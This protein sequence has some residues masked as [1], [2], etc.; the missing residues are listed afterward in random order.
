MTTKK[1][2]SMH[3]VY[4][5]SPGPATL[6][7]EVLEQ[8]REEMLDWR[9]SGMSIIEMSHR[10][11]QFMEIAGEAEQDCRELLAIPDSYNVL[12]LQGGATL[13]FA[14]VPLNIAGPDAVVNYVNT[15]SWSKKAIKEAER[16]CRVH[17]AADSASL[18]YNG[19]P[20]QREWNVDPGGAYLHYTPNE[21]IG[22]VEFHF[23]PDSHGV[24]LVADMSSTV[25][26][27]PI[28]VSRF[29]VIYAG[30][31]KNI[32]PSG[33]TLV[34]VRED[35]V[36]KARP[37]TPTVMNYQVMADTGSMSNTPN[38]FAWYMAGLVFKW[39][40][41]QGG[42]GVMGERNQVKAEK[43]YR[44]IDRSSFYHNPVEASSRSCMNVPFTLADP[45]LD[46]VFL[47]QAAT[48]GLVNLKGHRSVGGMRASLYNAMPEAGV[49]ALVTFM[50]EFEQV[51]R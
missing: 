5:F 7:V 23:I 14:S 40:K 22:G 34:I 8:V 41:T 29:G 26:S 45:D 2:K 44:A 18:E 37:D 28:D 35:L 27:R 42:L 30:A 21:T 20:P 43:L 36:G 38:T 50:D 19:I 31:Q 15:G 39:I 48:N 49:D 12:F 24:P 17:V 1:T 9:G 47:E 46:P 33:L 25:F 51:H 13:Q 3:R 16:Y 11:K 6:P 32:G 10:G 4:N